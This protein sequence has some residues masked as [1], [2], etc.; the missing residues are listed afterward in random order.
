[1]RINVPKN[2]NVDFEPAV[3]SIGDTVRRLISDKRVQAGIASIPVIGWLG[4]EYK[5]HKEKSE[6]E[7]QIRLFQEAL[8]KHQAIIDTLEN[9]KEREAYKQR[10]WEEV[11]GKKV[12]V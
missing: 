5:R 12:E 11:T 2:I 4:S 10:L 1:M 9:H 6:Y 7:K 3:K 8:R